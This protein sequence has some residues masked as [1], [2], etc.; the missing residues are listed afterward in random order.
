M[1][2]IVGGIHSGKR[3]YAR[4][5][6]GLAEDGIAEGVLGDAPVVAGVE[7]LVAEFGV[8][9]MGI[10]RLADMLA[11]KR[12]VICCEVGAGIVPLDAGERAWREDVGRLCCELAERAD[13]VVRMVCG[14]PQV[15]RGDPEAAADRGA[16]DDVACDGL[17]RVELIR[18]GATEGNARR[19]YVGAR[20]DEPLS[21][22][23]RAALRPEPAD[24]GVEAVFTSGMLR[25]AQTAGAL[26]PH[27]RQ[28]AVPDLR[29][30]DFGAFEGGSAADMGDDAAYRAWV[31]GGCEGACPEGESRAVFCARVTAAFRSV[32][33]C[34]AARGA[35]RAVFVVHGGTVMALRSSLEAGGPSYFDAGIAPGGRWEGAWDG[36]RLAPLGANP[37]RASGGERS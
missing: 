32:M 35:R 27:A 28:V 6:L 15:L 8:D 5:L 3:T 31:D 20:T 25:C 29:E 17:I 34:L 12:A 23:G 21:A 24:A 4:R 13:A 22:E 1:I 11:G 26:F 37:D 36:C 30:M 7:S 18:H 10:S 9:G 19:R 33:A 14:I 16:P 2:L